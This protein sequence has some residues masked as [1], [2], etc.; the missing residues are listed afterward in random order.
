LSILPARRDGHWIFVS[1]AEQLAEI[2]DPASD[3]FD[4]DFFLPVSRLPDEELDAKGKRDLWVAETFAY[5]GIPD[6]ARESAEDLGLVAVEYRLKDNERAAFHRLL[7]PAGLSLL[8]AD[9]VLQTLFAFM[10][11]R[12]AFTL[13]KGRVDPH[14]LAFGRITAD[15]GFV[16]RREGIRNTEGWL[17][18]KNNDGSYRHNFI[19]DYLR[20]L[21]GLSPEQTLSLAEGIWDFLTDR[22]LAVV[23]QDKRNWKLDHERLFVTKPA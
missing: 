18:R 19:T 1:L 13:P 3:K 22:S 15:I 6:S 11:H 7:E 2:A 4:P 12:K 20:R 10:R 21:L 23:V 9:G 16:L 5:F 8:D 17:P 14:A